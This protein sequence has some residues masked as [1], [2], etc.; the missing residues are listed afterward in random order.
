MGRLRIQ[1]AEANTPPASLADIPP[2]APIVGIHIRADFGFGGPWH[3]FA[4]NL[5]IGFG[6]REPIVFNFEK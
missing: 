1:A 4:D 6:N 3:G 2:D 5:T